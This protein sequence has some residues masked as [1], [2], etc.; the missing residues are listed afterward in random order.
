MFLRTHLDVVIITFTA[1]LSPAVVTSGARWNS[2]HTTF[3]AECV[4]SPLW[5]ADTRHPHALSPPLSCNCILLYINAKDCE[6][7]SLTPA[8]DSVAVANDAAI[9][10]HCPPSPNPVV[11]LSLSNDSAGGTAAN[12]PNGNNLQWENVGIIP[13][14]SESDFMSRQRYLG[15]NRCVYMCDSTYMCV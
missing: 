8:K 3:E 15:D 10:S 2:F 13:G 7:G 1:C 5:P 11:T 12:C 9:R 4:T 14:L 6:M